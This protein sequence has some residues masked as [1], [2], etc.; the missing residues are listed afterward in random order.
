MK[1]MP[2][3]PK[4]VLNKIKNNRLPFKWDLNI[5]RGCQHSCIYCYAIYSHDYLN[6]DNFFDT[7]YYKKNFL[8]LL[9]KKLSGPSWKHEVINIGGVTDSYQ[10]IESK[11]EIMPDVLKLM[12]KYKNPIIISTKSTLIY[13]DIDLINELSMLTYVNVAFT[14]TTLDD[15]I[16]KIIEPDASNSLSR[17]KVLKEFV[18]KTN[19]CTGVH[20]M[21]IIPY[22]ND[23]DKNLETIYNLSNK[24][25]VDYVLPG[26]LYLR[27]KTK[28]YFFNQ[29]RK[30][31]IKT[32]HKLD[33]LYNNS[34]ALKQYKNNLYKKINKFKDNYH[35]SH[36]YLKA[37]KSKL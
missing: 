12:I 18:E 22:L 36:D 26:I 5:Y 21:P 35:I 27:G 13:R 34:S 32:Y 10:P 6:D 33:T 30:Y 16:Q 23:I 25:N 24:I 4:T 14:I 11:L 2:I 17:F 1:Y 19:A 28:P 20:I 31:D 7:I 9:E 3:E 15:Q 37:I 8:N 29:I